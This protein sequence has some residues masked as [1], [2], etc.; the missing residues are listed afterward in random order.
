[1]AVGEPVTGILTLTAGS[2]AEIKPP[3]GEAWMIFNILIPNGVTEVE[4]Y[5]TNGTDDILVDTNDASW[6]YYKFIITDTHYIKLV[7]TGTVDV[8]V[9]Y[10]G[11]KLT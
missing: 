6:I 1:M 3:S 8:P 10:E 4:L 2:S 7:N 5:I 11:V 9:G